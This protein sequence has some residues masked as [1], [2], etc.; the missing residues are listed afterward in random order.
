LCPTW[1]C[2]LCF[3]SPQAIIYLNISFV[4][5]S[6][7]AGERFP[8]DVLLLFPMRGIGVTVPSLV[9]DIEKTTNLCNARYVV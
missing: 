7:Q 9:E 3:S 4:K 8:L 1:T 5:K 2:H 6:A